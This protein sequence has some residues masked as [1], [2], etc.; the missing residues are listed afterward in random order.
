M[1]DLLAQNPLL[2]LFTVIGVGYLVGNINL[3][4]LKLGVAAVLFAGM[5]FGAL[6][7]RLSLPEHIHVIGSVLF[8]YAIGLQAGPVF[9]ASFRKRGLRFSMMALGILALGAAGAFA[10]ARLLE[11]PEAGVAGLFC[12]ALTNTPAL[13]AAVETTRNLSGGLTGATRDLYLDGPVIAYGLT[14]PFGVFGVILAFV[15]C[16]KVFKLGRNARAME[17]EDEYAPEPIFSRTFRITNPALAGRKVGEAFAALKDHGFVLSR[18]RKGD[19]VDVVTSETVLDPGD[20]VVAVGGAQAME[21]ALLIFGAAAAEHLTPGQGGVGY[22]RIFVS[23]KE[24]VGKSIRELHLL[25]DL[26]AVITRL[27]RG[28]V[29]IVPRPDTVLEMGDRIRVITQRDNMDRVTRYFGDSIKSISETDF[30]SL[31]LGIV[32]GVFLGMIPIPLGHGIRFQLGFAGGAL[33]MGLVLG[34]LER[35]GP[36]TWDMPFH[37]NL[38]LRQVGLVFFLAA[39]GTR[40]GQGFGTLFEAGGWRMIAAGALLTTFVTACSILVGIRFLKLPMQAVMGLVS[41]IQTQSACLAWAN[42]QTESDLPNIW[43][44]TVYPSSIVIKIVLSQLI[45]SVVMMR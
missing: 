18:I 6:D 24:V 2:L 14:Y 38:V 23:N 41:G 25:R 13:A 20:H 22:R 33:V 10:V 34:R 31:S 28:D 40:A 9:F 36:V 35:T 7:R 42:Q 11:L 43:Y 8:L 32:L 3:F 15:L 12:G 19:R 4:G 29:D 44:T 30:L 27:R 5:F 17:A 21:R 1:V 39:I 16:N 37:A 26:H 45:V